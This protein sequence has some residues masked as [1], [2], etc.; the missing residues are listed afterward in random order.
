MKLKETQI[1]IGS[2][3]TFNERRAAAF[4]S[5]YIRILTGTPVPTVTDDTAAKSGEIVVGRT[6]RPADSRFVRNAGSPWEYSSF[7]DNGSFYIS[8]IGTAPETEPPYN[9]AYR[10]PDDGCIGTVAAAYRFVELALGC[11]FLNAAYVNFPFNPE[12]ELSEDFTLDLTRERLLSELPKIKD[13]PMIC[14]I[15]CGYHLDCNMSGTVMKTR[16]GELIVIDGGRPSDAEHLLSVIE[17]LSDG[18]KPVISAWFFT[19]LHVDHYGAICKIAKT[20]ELASKLEVKAFYHHLLSDNFYLTT[21]K[22]KAPADITDSRSVLTE[23]DK[24]FPGCEVKAV[25]AGDVMDID[26]FRFEILRVPDESK[27]DLMNYNDSSVVMRLDA[28]GQAWLLLADAEWVASGDLMALPAEKLKA[29]VVQVG[30]HGCG[31]VCREVYRRIDAKASIW[32]TGPLFYYSERGEGAGTHN[33]GV[34]RTR[35]WL[36]GLG[37]KPCNDRLVMDKLFETKLP[38]EIY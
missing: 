28:E 37:M 36:R 8:G 23:F 21:P 24:Y 35:Y 14:S 33:T 31:N 38:M 9:T 2:D 10:I 3:A 22:E 19:H 17:S 27:H 34:I 15:P 29:D 18:K 25:N 20:P 7:W 12:A 30:H 4:I 5:E 16:N 32:Q 6:S 1:V 11:D 26:G 13:G